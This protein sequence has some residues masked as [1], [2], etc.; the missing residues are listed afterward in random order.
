MPPPWPDNRILEQ[1]YDTAS[2]VLIRLDV[3]FMNVEKRTLECVRQAAGESPNHIRARKSFEQ[4]QENRA[5]IWPNYE[6]SLLSCQRA[7]SQPRPRLSRA[8]RW[9]WRCLSAV[10][11]CW[12][13]P[14]F[15]VHL[16]AD[17]AS[18]HGLQ[19]SFLTF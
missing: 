5:M 18:S 11:A 13:V 7:T 3:D 1:S 15:S 16:V 12:A 6:P 8:D 2:P 19:T 4:L 10:V 17:R 9:L 14:M